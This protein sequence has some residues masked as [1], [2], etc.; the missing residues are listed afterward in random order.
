MIWLQSSEKSHLL[1]SSETPRKAYIGETFVESSLTEKLLGI[2]SDSD[3]NFDEH[4]S[5]IC[6]KVAKKINVL[7]RLVNYM[8]LGN[9]RMVTKA[10]KNLSWII[11]L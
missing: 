9:R 8:S 11:V 3:L 1:L 7:S 5:S 4:I 6:N 2:Q 10:F